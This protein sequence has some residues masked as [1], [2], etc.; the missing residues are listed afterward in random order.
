MLPTIADILV[1]ETVR[2]GNPRVVAG[3]DRLDT[4]VRWVHVGEIADIAQLLRGGELVLTTGVALPDDP[5]KLADY[6][7]ELSAVGA[8]GLI[9]ELGRR[10]VRE[11]PAAVVKIR[12]GA[13]PAADR[14]DPRDAVRADHRG[15]ARPDHRHP[16]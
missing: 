12:R 1:L 13:R 8:S 3:A 4:K 2:R 15:R 16:A 5:G 7:A 14:A 10:F 9:V 11:L 6:I